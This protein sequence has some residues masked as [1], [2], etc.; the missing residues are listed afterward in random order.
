MPNV[1]SFL[2]F[3][4]EQTWF[5]GSFKF[6][7]VKQMEYTYMYS[8]GK[9]S[10]MATKT[11]SVV[12]TVQ[13]WCKR[14]WNLLCNLA[15]RRFIKIFC[16]PPFLSLLA[17]AK[18]KVLA[19]KNHTEEWKIHRFKCPEWAICQVCSTC[20]MLT[21]TDWLQPPNPAETYE[22]RNKSHHESQ[23]KWSMRV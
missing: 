9:G 16:F 15:S 7:R 18:G 8:F 14:L 4:G 17:L 5:L 21:H 11:E 19:P 22:N 20:R 6:T 23:H 13:V 1:L 3:F 2:F 12:S 10:F